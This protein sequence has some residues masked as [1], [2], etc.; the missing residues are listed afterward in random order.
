M[1]VQC[2]IVSS[3]RSPPRCFQF[4]ILGCRQVEILKKTARLGV[5]N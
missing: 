2:D 1:P 4:V 3:H 5:S